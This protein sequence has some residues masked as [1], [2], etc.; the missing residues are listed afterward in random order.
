MANLQNIK[1]LSKERKIS[2]RSISEHLGVTEQGLHKMIREETMSAVVLEKVARILNVNVCVFF[3]RDILC[4]HVEEYNSTGD[5]AI[6][7]KN[8]G[9][10]DQRNMVPASSSKNTQDEDLQAKVI[11]LQGELLN[12]QS[13]IINLLKN[14]NES[15]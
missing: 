5:R 11:T 8:I 3:D 9:R 12:A 10:N 13:E 4:G 2:L 7:A 1:T 15:K 14:R 6:A